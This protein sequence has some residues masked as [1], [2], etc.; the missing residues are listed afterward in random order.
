MK[1]ELLYYL[2]EF[3]NI[4]FVEMKNLELSKNLLMNVENS[5][6]FNSFRL[7][8]ILMFFKGEELSG[9]LWMVCVL[10]SK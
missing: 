10:F 5:F 2:V 3:L 6:I 4:F 8:I 1:Y 7:E 9:G